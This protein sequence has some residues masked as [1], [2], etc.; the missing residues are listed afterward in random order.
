MV[1]QCWGSVDFLLEEAV[2]ADGERSPA[3]SGQ[4]GRGCWWGFT[5][6]L[7]VS[8]SPQL[9][10][11]LGDAGHRD[12]TKHFGKIVQHAARFVFLQN[13]FKQ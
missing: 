1:V 3:K 12:E 9:R 8:L 13:T 11:K 4:G 10:P 6:A 5:A 7:E 2:A